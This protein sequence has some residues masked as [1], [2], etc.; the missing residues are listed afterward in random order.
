MVLTIL[1]ISFI[2][3]IIT[4]IIS[5][6]SIIVSIASSILCIISQIIH[7]SAPLRKQEILACQPCIK[8]PTVLDMLDIYEIDCSMAC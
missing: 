8:N 1:I 5:N 6:I 3:G 2:V 4:I 7:G